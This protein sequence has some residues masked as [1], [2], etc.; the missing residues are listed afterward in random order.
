[1]M[2]MPEKSTAETN[3]QTLWRCQE[4]S[5]T[6]RSLA[7]APRPQRTLPSPVEMPRDSWFGG[8]E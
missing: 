3:C 1:M 4:E 7:A 6:A 2:A 8:K 5:Y